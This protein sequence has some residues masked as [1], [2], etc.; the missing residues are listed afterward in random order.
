MTAHTFQWCVTWPAALLQVVP[1]FLLVDCP[2]PGGKTLR[3]GPT[4][5]E[6]RR[7]KDDPPRPSANVAD[8]VRGG[9]LG[10]VLLI[11]VYVWGAFA[12]DDAA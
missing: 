5:G 12:A 7:G 4:P 9:C 6:E 1:A 11:P 8:R 2:T 3:V 10:L